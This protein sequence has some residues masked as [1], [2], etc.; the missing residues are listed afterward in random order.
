M[1]DAAGGDLGTMMIR[2]GIA[3]A[4]DVA[5][6]LKNLTGA[7]PQVGT[8][9][10]R[11]GAGLGSMNAPMAAA[12]ASAGELA[13]SLKIA[14]AALAVGMGVSGYMNAQ[15][16]SVAFERIYG[17][18]DKA[19]SVMK[20]LKE[21]AMLTGDD[22]NVLRE[23]ANRLAVMGYSAERMLPVVNAL[24]DLERLA[25]GLPNIGGTI[26]GMLSALQQR[27]DMAAA[28]MMLRGMMRSGVPLMRWME[29]GGVQVQGIGQSTKFY[30]DGRRMTGE[31]V[32]DEIVSAIQRRAGGLDKAPTLERFLKGTKTALGSFMTPTGELLAK[33]GGGAAMGGV[34]QMAIG[35][36]RMNE[37][38]QGVLGLGLAAL[39]MR[40][41][42]VRTIQTVVA[43]V[44]AL[45][46]LQTQLIGTAV[47]AGG[48]PGAAG[49]GSGWYRAGRGLRGFMRGPGPGIAIGLGGAAIEG[50][51][52]PG[53]TQ[54]YIGSMMAWGGLGF[55][56]G[57]TKG[58][59]GAL[60]GLAVGMAYGAMKA[61]NNG[62]SRDDAKKGDAN[63]PYLK[64]MAE[65]LEKVAVEIV[66]GGPRA[67]RSQGVLQAEITAARLARSG[68]A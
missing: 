33:T 53:S 30:R 7:L 19:R 39:W 38:S 50:G 48:S 68:W 10:Q 28:G 56:I 43:L 16:F 4:D 40:G 63:T 5:A 66:G 52:E 26:L 67:G 55:A 45:G 36:A 13:A 31:E 35:L 17:S 24:N 3:G 58:P 51:A 41:S 20:A 1:A 21:E 65:T 62:K 64:R 44:G 6:Q 9:A 42:I 34:Q 23:Y 32:A 11:A 47:A 18:A 27:G 60:A 46:R 15:K 8:A 61:Y 29:E 49:G 2:I 14:G 37:A 22:I 25:P 54:D 59:Y 57:G 12:A